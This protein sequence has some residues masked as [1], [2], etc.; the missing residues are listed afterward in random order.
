VK[1][2][3]L[4][5][6]LSPRAVNSDIGFK[7]TGD[8]PTVVWE[9]VLLALQGIPAGRF[10]FLMYAYADDDQAHHGFFAELFMDA[11]QDLAVH[12]WIIGRKNNGNYYR[13]VELMCR[14]AVEEWKG[15][16][17]QFG[18][19]VDRANFMG[20]SRG[21]W[22]RRY[23]LVYGTILTRPTIWEAE[24]MKIVTDRLT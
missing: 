3:E 18:T 21:T 14:L 1:S 13:D 7:I 12:R 4:F 8:S 15:G 9:D 20:V 5:S 16:D 17:Y 6:K 19:Q 10:S 11:M 2:A 23:H 22:K 24:I